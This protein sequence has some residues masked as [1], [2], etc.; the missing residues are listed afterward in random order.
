MT[1]DNIKRNSTAL[2]GVGL[3]V[4]V[5]GIIAAIAAVAFIFITYPEVLENVLYAILI[6]IGVIIVIAVVIWIIVALAAV[7]MYMIKGEE[8]QDGSS[9]NIDNLQPVGD[10]PNADENSKPKE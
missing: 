9:Y 7:P 6:I 3:L 1:A 8:F 2:S 5:V 4:I 10:K